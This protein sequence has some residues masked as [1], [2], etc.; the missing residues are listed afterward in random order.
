MELYQLKEDTKAI[1]VDELLSNSGQ[2]EHRRLE[3]IKKLYKSSG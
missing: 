2:Y 3:N 1:G